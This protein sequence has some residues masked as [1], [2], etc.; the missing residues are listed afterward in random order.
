MEVVNNT[1][2]I[3]ILQ[4]I[5]ISNQDLAHPKLIQC[6]VSIYLNKAGKKEREGHGLSR[7][8]KTVE[9]QNVAMCFQQC[10]WQRVY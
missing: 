10:S 9:R 2:V 5:N 4:F 6:Y 1:I 8:H 7:I 3:I